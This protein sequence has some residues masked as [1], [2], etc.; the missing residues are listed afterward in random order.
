MSQTTNQTTVNNIS[1][2]FVRVGKVKDAHGIKGELFVLIFSGETSWLPKLKT[3]RLV[4]NETGEAKT[5]ELTVKSARVHKNGLI[6]KTEEL[7]DRNEAESLCGWLFDLPAEF[8]VSEKGEAIYLREI[9]GFAVVTKA[10]GEIG[11]IVGFGSNGGQDLLVVKT[12]WG[13]FEIPFVAAFVDKIDYQARVVK[14]NLPEGLLGEF[15]VDNED[16]DYEDNGDDDSDE[17]DEA[18]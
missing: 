2:Q 8:F 5:R 11:T 4:E 1:G 13:E 9:E 3:L 10:K 14:M 18:Q 7:K 17:S 6:V 15:D 16:D 12:G